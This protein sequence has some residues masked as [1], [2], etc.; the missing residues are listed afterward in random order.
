MK[1][2]RVVTRDGAS[3]GGETQCKGGRG[4]GDRAH[5]VCALRVVS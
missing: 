4:P 5:C 3:A 2:V 1:E